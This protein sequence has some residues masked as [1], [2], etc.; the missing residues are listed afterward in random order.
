ML[1][2]DKAGLIMT[3]MAKEK[4]VT[5]PVAPTPATEETAEK[6]GRSGQ[7]VNIYVDDDIRAAVDAYIR[8]HNGKHDHKAT[9]RSTIEASIRLYL[10][11]H[12]FW[13]WPKNGH[14]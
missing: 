3:V 10:K 4:P 7:P 2:A 13:P 1:N 5:K 12:G 14:K 6:S 8:D 11:A 9:L